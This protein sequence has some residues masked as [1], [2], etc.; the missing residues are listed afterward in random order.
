[1]KNIKKTII[2]NIQT[3]IIALFILGVYK[4]KFT[5]EK[6]YKSGFNI[7]AYGAVAGFLAFNVSRG[8]SNFQYLF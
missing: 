4:S 5:K 8:I 7:A 2:D 6:W 3:I 1:M